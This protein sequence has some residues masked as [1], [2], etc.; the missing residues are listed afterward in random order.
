MTILGNL[1][2][3]CIRQGELASAVDALH[4]TIDALEDT[5][6]AGG[7]NLAFSAGQELRQWRHHTSVQEL[8]DRLFDLM[9]AG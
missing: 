8:N 5:R 6:G 4:Q 9:A 3:A 7:L 2:L 1:A